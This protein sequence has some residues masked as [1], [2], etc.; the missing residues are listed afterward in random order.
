[1][2]NFRCVVKTNI[3]N[4]NDQNGRQT[5][6]YPHA[7]RGGTDGA[8]LSYMGLPCPNIFSGAENMHGRYEF[9][10]VDTMEKAVEVI[11]N[12]ARMGVETR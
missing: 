1:L 12:I 11:V 7:V 5:N 6:D 9:V 3:W 4:N 2:Y 8:R 10:S